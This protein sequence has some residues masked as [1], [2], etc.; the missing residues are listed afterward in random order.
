[1]SVSLFVPAAPHVPRTHPFGEVIQFPD[2]ILMAASSPMR[3]DLKSAVASTTAIMTDP[4]QTILQ[5]G[6]RPTTRYVLAWL[7]ALIT[8]SVSLYVAWNIFNDD[9]R[10]DGNYG[11]AHIDFGG[12]WLMGRMLVEGHGQQLYNRVYQRPVLHRAYPVADGVPLDQRREEE[13]GKSDAEKLMEWLMGTDDQEAANGLAPLL[14]P[15]AAGD[16]LGSLG[17]FAAASESKA[18]LVQRLG[19]R[20]VGGALYPP[21]NAFVA[22]PLAL[23]R[24]QPAYRVNQAANL[25]LAFVSGLG[26]QLIARGRIWCPLAAAVIIV[27]PG[28]P[29]SI[30]LAQ[31]ATLTLT[32][33]I[34]GWVLV[35]RGHPEWGGAVWGLLVFKPVWGAAFFL[36][37]LLTGRWR[38]G[39]SMVVAAAALAA[40]TVPVVG[41][42]S[43]LDWLHIG[44]EATLLYNTDDTWIHLSR[45]LLSL[46][47]RWLLDFGP[48][49]ERDPYWLPP[50]LIGWCFYLAVLEVTVRIAVLRRQQVGALEGPVAAFLFLGAWMS[51]FH[52]MYYD[53]LL[54]FVPVMLLFTDPC[55]Y[56]RPLIVTLMPV[57]RLEPRTNLGD[58]F[59]PRLADTNPPP[60]PLLETGQRNLWVVNS[61]TPSLVA[62]L[63]AA[64]HLLPGLG[65]DLYAGEP[66]D[67][68]CLLALWLWCGWLWMSQRHGEVPWCATDPGTA[69]EKSS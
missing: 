1:M 23:M 60:L 43:W 41:W 27:F 25:V 37:P 32:I 4:W 9:R 28:F 14:S 13:H 2:G 30:H 19:A 42:Q 52:F 7:V 55:R 51:C 15:L 49:A 29:A 20:H 6:L 40:A 61:M 44:R 53:L 8:A 22:Y 38:M 56:L 45:D 12:Q 64:A 18:D 69:H 58:Y 10:A 16:A 47:R 57:S 48:D 59:R 50:A 67:T 46:P 17:L 11:H 39:L 35:C 54:A 21:I 63:F 36:V 31:N 5:F 68:Y 3:A 62:A 24:P 34:W 26:V 33:L 66:W 65:V